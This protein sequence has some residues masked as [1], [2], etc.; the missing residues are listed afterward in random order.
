[1]FTIFG[2]IFKI[3]EPF[4]IFLKKIVFVVQ[5]RKKVMHGLL[6][7]FDKYAKIMHFSQFLKKFFE[8][9]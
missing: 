4:K 2:R 7:P 9:F 8:N 5:T 1:M 6:N 3:F